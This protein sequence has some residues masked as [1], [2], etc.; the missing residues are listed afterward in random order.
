MKTLK[1]G[2]FGIKL[3]LEIQK[4]LKNSLQLLY[5]EMYKVISC[6]YMLLS[7]SQISKKRNINR[8]NG[9]NITFKCINS[10]KIVRM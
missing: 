1:I 6:F 8:L 3:A 7:S 5:I 9:Y 4:T 10:C 2:F